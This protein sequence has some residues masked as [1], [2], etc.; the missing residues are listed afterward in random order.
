[1]AHRRSTW[2]RHRLATRPWAA[3]SNPRSAAAVHNEAEDV[4]QCAAEALSKDVGRCTAEVSSSK[5]GNRNRKGEG[6]EVNRCAA[7]AEEA[8]QCVVEVVEAGQ[9]KAE[10]VE[11][12]RCE[13]EAEEDVVRCKAEAVS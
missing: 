7:E 10:A 11:V 1:M 12:G 4:G 2:W 6:E 9:C 8:G 13:A 5:E 3:N